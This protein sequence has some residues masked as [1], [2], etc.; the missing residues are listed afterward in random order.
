MIDNLNCNYIILSY[1]NE[2]LLLF[3]DLKKILLTKGNTIL[4]KIEY[5]KFKS[6]KNVKIKKVIEYIWF[7]DTKKNNNKYKEIFINKN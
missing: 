5:N 1:N 7:I 3:D 2:G 4:Y 6:Q